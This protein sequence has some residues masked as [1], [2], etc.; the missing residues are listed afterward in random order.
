MAP[1]KSNGLTRKP[2]IW[3]KNDHSNGEVNNARDTKIPEKFIMRYSANCKTQSY[4]FY[5][6][7]LDKRVIKIEDIT[8]RK[9]A[10][11]K[12]IAIAP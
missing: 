1:I 4:T 6:I 11:K 3:N 7:L 8:N 12:S 2:D 10:V 9:R 5:S